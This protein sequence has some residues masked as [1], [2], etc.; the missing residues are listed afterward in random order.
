MKRER[1][2]YLTIS[3]S[4]SSSVFDSGSDIPAHHPP[5]ARTPQ[6][7]LEGTFPPRVVARKNVLHQRQVLAYFQAKKNKNIRRPSALIG[8]IPF[9]LG[10]SGHVCP[11]EELSLHVV[12][13]CSAA[14]QVFD[15]LSHKCFKLFKLPF[16]FLFLSWVEFFLFLFPATGSR[17]GGRLPLYS[18]SGSRGPDRQEGPAHQTT[19]P[20]R[21]SFH[22]GGSDSVCLKYV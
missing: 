13:S 18:N 21:R 7:C 15:R 9:I 17:A 4:Q 20:L 11:H 1:Q 16:F 5:V 14:L 10:P 19:R 2:T 3:T 8:N 6:I 12:T 22:Q